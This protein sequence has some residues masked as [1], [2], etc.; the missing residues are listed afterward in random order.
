MTWLN[1]M[2]PA[3]DPVGGSSGSLHSLQ[4]GVGN[5]EPYTDMHDDYKGT[6]VDGGASF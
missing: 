1:Q 3:M 4:K 2:V 5:L 6:N